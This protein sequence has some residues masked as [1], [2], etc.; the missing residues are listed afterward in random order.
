MHIQMLTYQKLPTKIVQN[1]LPV[2]SYV[3]VYIL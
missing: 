3:Y 2:T 1:Q